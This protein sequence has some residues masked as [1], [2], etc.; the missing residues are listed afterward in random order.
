MYR[1]STRTI[2][3]L[4]FLA[5]LSIVL[6]RLASFRIPI[7]AVEGVRIG[8]GGLPTIFAGLMFGPLAGGFVGVV[9]D[10]VGYLINPIGAYMPHFTF[11]AFLTG[12]I[13]A[14]IILYIFRQKRSIPNLA[15]AIGLGQL[16]TT[17]L[18][19]PYFLHTLFALPFASVSLANFISQAITVPLY[20]YVIHFLFRYSFF[21][22]H[23]LST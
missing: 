8:F 11:S 13:P 3:L 14:T 18:L 6:T 2:V 12:V 17:V 16:I 23:Q 9:S 1:F 7:G 20:V 15:V 4:S 19:V 21:Q 10:V 22:A 5:A